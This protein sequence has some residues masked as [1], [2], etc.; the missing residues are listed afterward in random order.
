VQDL[1]VRMHGRTVVDRVGFTVEPGE[2]VCLLGASGSGKSL[3]ARAV[4][5]QSLPGMTLSGQIRVDGRDVAGRPPSQRPPRA[6]VAM[7]FQDSATALHPLLT[8]GA[9][10]GMS[11]RRQGLPAAV[12]R[13]RVDDLLA[14]VGLQMP[15]LAG[16]VPS[17]LS[18][19]QRQ[20]ACIAL[21]LGSRPR[22][23]IA[24]EP[25]TA[26]DV[27]AQAAVLEVLR[28]QVDRGTALVFI[29]HDLA[30]AARL[31]DRAVVLADGRVVEDGALPDL[32]GNAQHAFTRELV[33]AA[34]AQA[35]PTDL[36]SEGAA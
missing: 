27:V 1:T 11:L 16:R 26:L 14:S 21:A 17:Q 25:T 28:E 4:V 7:V 15:G 20:R 29:T 30:V 36:D 32:L 23:L 31:C 22:V 6:R 5:G 8:L 19:G 18:G 13:D 2:R 9:Q 35:L 3:T 34:Y 24:D 33:A 10:L 12:T